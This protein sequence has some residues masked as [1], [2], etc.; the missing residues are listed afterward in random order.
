M[1]WC[2]VMSWCHDLMSCSDIASWCRVYLNVIFEKAF[3]AIIV[4]SHRRKRSWQSLNQ[5][6]YSIIAALSHCFWLII[7]TDHCTRSLH[8]VIALG[9]CTRSLHLVIAFGHCIRSLHLVIAFGHCTQLLHS[10]TSSSRV[11]VRHI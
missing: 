4:A 9:H 8:S 3:I 10:V 2:H 1:P 11:Q 5:S 6:L 7:A